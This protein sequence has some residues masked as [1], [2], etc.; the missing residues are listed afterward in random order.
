MRYLFFFLLSLSGL[1]SE[2]SVSDFLGQQKKLVQE[3]ARLEESIVSCIKPEEKKAFLYQQAKIFLQLQHNKE[4]C[5][6]FLAALSYDGPHVLEESLD[7]P[8]KIFLPMYLFSDLEG[9]EAFLKEKLKD[10][11]KDHPLYMMYGGLLANRGDFAAFFSIVYDSCL[12]HPDSFFTWNIRGMLAARIFEASDQLEERKMYQKQAIEYFLLAFEK[13]PVD[14]R[15]ALRVLFFAQGDE[16]KQYAL[17]LYTC[18]QKCVLQSNLVNRLLFQEVMIE[19]LN[20]NLYEQVT[21]MMKQ[22]EAL[23]GYSRA[24]QELKNELQELQQNRE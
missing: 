14:M 9:Q 16:K 2:E 20:L 18:M 22:Y 24:V 12:A 7:A 23:F 1:F 6:A 19:F 5:Q 15:L 17:R 11:K 4:A 21:S 13:M 10:V 8:T 3:C